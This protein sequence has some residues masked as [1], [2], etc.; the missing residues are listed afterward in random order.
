MISIKAKNN[1]DPELIKD[2]KLKVRFVKGT[3]TVIWTEGSYVTGDFS[4]RIYYLEVEKEDFGILKELL[5]RN[6]I[7]YCEEKEGVGKAVWRREGRNP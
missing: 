3:A 7:N 1:Y 2:T 5:S 6:E 4:D